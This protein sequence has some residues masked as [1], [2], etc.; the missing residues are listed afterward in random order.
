MRESLESRLKQMPLAG[1][2]IKGSIRMMPYKRYVILYSVDED[3]RL[4]KLLHIFG[5]G[6][7]WGNTI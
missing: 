4:V 5:G 2:K 3:E 7:D 1:K 6:Q